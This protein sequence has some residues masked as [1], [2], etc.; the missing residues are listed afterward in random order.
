MSDCCGIDS[1]AGAQAAGG[2]GGGVSIPAMR[3][4]TTLWDYDLATQASANIVGGANTIDAPTWGTGA[5][6]GQ[7]AAASTFAFQ[8][9]V[10]LRY[11]SSHSAST[12]FT[13]GAGAQTASLIYLPLST[14]FSTFD[15]DPRVPLLYQIQISSQT[16]TISGEET[17]VGFWKPAA[18]P[19]A[20]DIIG[21]GVTVRGLQV[22]VNVSRMHVGTSTSSNYTTAPG[23]TADVLS[24]L[25]TPSNV[26]TGYIGVW[27]GSFEDTHPLT[28]ILANSQ[29]LGAGSGVCN[30]MLS[31]VSRLTIAFPT[32]VTAGAHDVTVRRVR[33]AIPFFR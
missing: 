1:V 23:P 11:I 25:V 9:G 28:M 15:I 4:G 29:S 2:G 6:T 12:S 32:V 31:E 21:F 26:A 8:S 5:W 14:V 17:S 13:G 22:G 30:H 19:T 33:L 20:A 16:Y 3:D 7:V 10:G 24:T 27:A 18:T